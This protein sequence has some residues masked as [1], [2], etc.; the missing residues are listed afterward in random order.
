VAVLA[1][2][3]TSLKPGGILQIVGAAFSLA[4]ATLFPALVC[5][6]FWRRANRLGALLGMGVGFGVTLTYMIVTYPP[7]GINAP[8]WWGIKPIAAG[9]FGVPAGFFA[10]IIGSLLSAPPSDKEAVVVDFI[11]APESPAG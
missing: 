7:F 4:A 1:A 2:Y 10:I 3:L 6:V 8:M 9:T 11:R 5:G